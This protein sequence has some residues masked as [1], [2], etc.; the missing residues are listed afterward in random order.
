MYL[1][2]K[3]INYLNNN[4]Y[5]LFLNPK[6]LQEVTNH[7]KKHSY[8]LYKPYPY[9]EKN[10]IYTYQEPP[11]TLYEIKIGIP[12]KHS[13][14][15]GTLYSL[16]IEDNLFGDIIVDNNHYYFYTYSYMKTFFEMEFLKIKNS[17]I[18]LIERD[19]NYL[20][21]YKPHFLEITI[22]NNSL[23]I[24]SIIAKVIHTNRDNVKEL[25]KDK[26][27]IYNCDIL[28]NNAKILHEGDTFSIRKF[29]KFK[30]DSILANTKKDNLVIQI[31]KY[32]DN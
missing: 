2:E 23:R 6:E 15:L 11:L 12:I 13:D 8:Y 16:Q 20:N 31:L 22:I 29:G 19:T 25:I 1:T 28:K 4:G 7:L 17:H 30:F 24:D 10:I 5:T 26:K 32:I 21:D 27:I 9:S 18:E 14:I 3:T